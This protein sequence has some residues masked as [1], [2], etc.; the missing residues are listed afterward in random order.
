MPYCI[1][2]LFQQD[3]ESSCSSKFYITNATE[4][5]NFK[6]MLE[7]KKTMLNVCLK[8]MRYV[9]KYFIFQTPCCNPF[10]NHETVA[11]YFSQDSKMKQKTELGF[12]KKALQ[13]LL[14]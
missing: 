3:C 2:L 14:V 8:H 7:A 1:S 12:L 9:S 6:Y 5:E 4:Q 11:M 13:P 10:Q